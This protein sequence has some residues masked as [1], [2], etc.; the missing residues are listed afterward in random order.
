MSL[1]TILHKVDSENRQCILDLTEHDPAARLLDC[2]CGNGDFTRRIAE[3]IG[4]SHL[5]GIEYLSRP[6]PASDSSLQI[7]NSDLNDRFPFEDE[8][9]DV[10]HANPVIEHL[11][12]TDLFIEE[13]YRVLKKGGSAIISTPNLVGLHNIFS[14][15]FGKQPF[16][17]H[18]SNKAIV[19][20]SFDPKHG[21]RHASRGEVHLRIFTYE[22]L[23]EIF[24]YHGFTVEKICG[25]G[26][27][28]LPSFIARILARIDAR[29]AVYLTLKV[30][31]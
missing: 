28:P 8:S 14:L 17:A 21:L 12:E 9:F 5:Y 1:L 7:V 22:S 3:I 20:N 29:H 10:I 6:D 16:S 15:F 24:K 25:G 2:G 23:I 19:G 31:K 4:T 30:R 26:Y 18:V 27:Y 11:H 13:V